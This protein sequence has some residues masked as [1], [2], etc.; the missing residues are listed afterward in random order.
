MA[1]TSCVTFP[2]TTVDHIKLEPNAKDVVV[3]DYISPNEMTKLIEVGK[4]ECR[5]GAN[6]QYFKDNLESCKNDLRNKAF[7]MGG[8]VVLVK[9]E[10]IKSYDQNE[11]E[12]TLPQGGPCGNCVKIKSLIYK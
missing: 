9:D 5:M 8:R 6:G 12:K 2:G 10:D 1:L 11:P 7:A 4:V 3:K